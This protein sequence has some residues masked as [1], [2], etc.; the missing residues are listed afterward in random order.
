MGLF[1]LK[2]NSQEFNPFLSQ[3]SIP[4]SVTVSKA[5]S[6]PDCNWITDLEMLS[7]LSKYFFLQKF[8]ST[9]SNI[10]ILNQVEFQFSQQFISNQ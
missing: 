6:L 1:N 9:D 5:V 8:E 10:C 7:F 3:V 4:I 2:E